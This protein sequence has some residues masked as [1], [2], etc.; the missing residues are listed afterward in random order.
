MSANRFEKTKEIYLGHSEQSSK[1]FAKKA[2]SKPMSMY[3]SNLIFWIV[4]FDIVQ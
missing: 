4:T 1:N 3:S 2:T